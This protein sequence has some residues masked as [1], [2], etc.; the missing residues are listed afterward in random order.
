[1]AKV[2][3]VDVPTKLN[4]YPVVESKAHENGHVTVLVQRDDPHDPYVVATWWQGLGTG[5]SWGHY[6]DTML[7]ASEDFSETCRRNERRGNV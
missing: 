6:F 7:R 1:M 4:G 3:E 5:W 2:L